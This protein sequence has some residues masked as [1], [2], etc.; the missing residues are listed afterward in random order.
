MNQH[1]KANIYSTARNYKLYSIFQRDMFH[2]LS[3]TE[4]VQNFKHAAGK[5][6]GKYFLFHHSL[7]AWY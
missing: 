4:S 1:L 5:N 7:Y 6:V 2:N 3:T